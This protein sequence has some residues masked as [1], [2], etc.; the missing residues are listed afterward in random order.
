M[1]WIPKGV[2]DAA[3]EELVFAV[4]P[5]DVTTVP[6]AQGVYVIE[7]L[8]KSKDRALDPAQKSPLAARAFADWVTEKTASLTIANN[9][10]LRDGDVDKIDWAV[11]RAYQ[12]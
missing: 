12:S 7:M 1:G 11:S 6:T 8:E 3:T 2:L 5:G 4:E 9:M 10:S